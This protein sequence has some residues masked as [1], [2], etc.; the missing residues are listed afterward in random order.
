MKLV[1]EGI[2]LFRTTY[3]D[4]SLIATFY[5]RDHGIK[6]YVFK[7]GKKKSHNLFPLAISELTYYERKE[8]DLSNLTSADPITKQSFPFDPVRSTIAFFI[9]EVIRKTV[10]QSEK[11][12]EL[13]AFLQEQIVN[14]DETEHVADLPIRFLVGLTNRLGI[15]PIVEEPGRTFKYDEGVI[16]NGPELI[17]SDSDAGEHV[18]YLSR[19]FL[20]ES[21]SV[22]HK[23]RNQALGTLIKYI[24]Y[25]IPRVQNLDTLEIVKEILS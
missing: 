17:S 25:Y 5:T 1:D 4:T 14:L 10:D 21:V 2:F 24:G 6:K 20:N 3:S 11:D 8:T 23:T 15:N 22:D 9:A 7:G 18:E 13:F 16:G 12:P 19:L